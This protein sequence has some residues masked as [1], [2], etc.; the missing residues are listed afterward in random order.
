MPD[1]EILVG[2]QEIAD[3]LRVHQD[4]AKKYYKELG[5]PVMKYS[6]VAWPV[7]TKR[8]IL[9][10]IDGRSKGDITRKTPS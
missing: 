1:S 4:T 3:F 10:W 8:S 2:W 6:R 5:M 7:A 9:D